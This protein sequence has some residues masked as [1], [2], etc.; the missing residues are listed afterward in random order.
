MSASHKFFNY[1]KNKHDNDGVRL[2]HSLL[3]I[4]H[5]GFGAYNILIFNRLSSIDHTP[6]KAY[7][8][9]FRAASTAEKNTD[10]RF[11]IKAYSFHTSFGWKPIA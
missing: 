11:R 9:I 1:F 3:V 8:S 6:S 5:S 10:I 2:T 4:C 7:S